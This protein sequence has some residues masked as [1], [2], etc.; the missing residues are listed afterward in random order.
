[1][2]WNVMKHE[3]KKAKEILTDYKG[4]IVGFV[5][6][7]KTYDGDGNIQWDEGTDMEIVFKDAEQMVTT[8]NKV[9]KDIEKAKLNTTTIVVSK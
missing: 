2:T 9:L 6:S 4:N 3:V 7:G 1:M 5:L 8:L